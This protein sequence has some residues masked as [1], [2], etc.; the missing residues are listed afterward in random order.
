MTEFDPTNSGLFTPGPTFDSA[1]AGDAQRQAVD[2]LRGYAY[3][4]TASALAWLDLDA[5]AKLYLEVAEDY[6]TVAESALNAVQVKDT[7]HSGKISLKSPAVRNAVNAYVDLVARNPQRRVELHFLT[8]AA[9][10]QEQ[11][12]GDRPGGEAGLLYWRKAALAADLK[13][14]RVAFES[15][16]FSDSVRAFVRARDDDG[17]RRELLRNI[18]WECEQQNLGELLNELEDRLIILCTDRYR[19]RAVDSKRLI[20]VLLYHVLQKSILKDA[21]A[22]VLARADL[23][24]LINSA[25][26]VTLQQSTVDA[27]LARAVS[28][29][30]GAVSSQTTL[31]ISPAESNWFI[32]SDDIPTPRGIIP[33][34][35][36]RDAITKV[37]TTQKTAFLVGS[38]GMGKSLVGREAAREIAGDF[39]IFDLRDAELSEMRLRLKSVLGRI[40]EVVPRTMILEDAN[41]LDDPNVMMSLAMVINALNR[42]DRFA[43][44]TCYRTPSPRTLSALNLDVNAVIEIPYF[45]EDEVKVVVETN[46]GARD[47]WGKIAYVAGGVGHPQLV[48]AFVI[49][50][51]ARGWPRDALNDVV[52]SG[53]QSQD[54]EAAKDAARRQLVAALPE[55]PRTLLYRLSLLVGP[56]DR[57][58][59]LELGSIPP[60]LK[61]PGDQLD[62]LVGSWIEIIGRHRYRISPLIGNAGREA[63]SPTDQ[64]AIHIAIAVRMVSGKALNVSD[65]NI[66]FAHALLGKADRILFAL[67]GSILQ[68]DQATRD[69]L[70]EHFFML[71]SA[72][73]DIPIYADNRTVSSM[74]RSAQ[75]KLVAKGAE[76]QIIDCKIAMLREFLA[77]PVGELRDAQE[78]LG[79]G[80]VL[81]TAGIAKYLPDWFQLIL[82]FIDVSE[83]DRIPA[84]LNTIHKRRTSSGEPNWYSMLFVIGMAQLQS[85]SRLGEIFG[86]LDGVSQERRAILLEAYERGPGS[87]HI[88]VSGPWLEETKSEAFNWADAADRYSRM[89]EHAHRWGIKRLAAEC[90]VARAVMLDEYGHRPEDALHALDEAAVVL[91]DD[92]IIARA[93]A[94]ILWRHDEHMG[95][96]VIMRGIADRISHDEPI[97][98]CFALREAAISAAKI[99]DWT[100]AERWFDEAKVSAD[101]AIADDMLPMGVG[102]GID[103]AVAAFE[104]GRPSEAIARFAKSLTDL[105]KI[106]P[107]LSLRAAYC[108]RVAR[109]AVLWLQSKVEKLDVLIEHQPIQVPPGT[110]SNPQPLEAI[111]E[112]P[113]GSIDVA[114]YLLAQVEV[115]SGA[116][117]G[118]ASTL[119]KRLE[120]GMIPA[121]EV[122]LRGKWLERAI[123][124]SDANIFAKHFREWLEGVAYLEAQKS[125]NFN[126]LNP[127]RGEVP[128]LLDTEL[129]TEHV[130][131]NAEDAVLAFFITPILDGRNVEFTEL[132][133]R[134]AAQMGNSFPGAGL[135]AQSREETS[136]DDLNQVVARMSSSLLKE[137]HLEPK[138][139]WLIGLRLFEKGRK[140][141]FKFLLLPRVAEWMRMQWTR[142]IANERFRLRRPIVN[143]PA[144]EGALANEYD[145]QQFVAALLLACEDTV[146]V[147]LNSNYRDELRR[148]AAGQ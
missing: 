18:H 39:A 83:S 63:L 16:D 137:Q 141:N 145:D 25:T 30:S 140:S 107:A 135:F 75:F 45:T 55:A 44:I 99:E 121:C 112:L 12:I 69:S 54:V 34:P 131:L 73:T 65:A 11:R 67:A 61:A 84:D 51:S 128:P 20:N 132:E 113:L 56:F 106:D 19:T 31:A 72:R 92:V 38:T 119:S 1:P 6:A 42:R 116:D 98:R 89:F 17:V 95:A 76:W 64:Q 122:M 96:V 133:S 105:E 115:I 91:G 78:L 147:S 124:N 125:T 109:H 15:T 136:A 36:V 81:N 53:L 86:E 10:T 57:P 3:Q 68:A 14:L 143:V 4:V 110:C 59:A 97:A 2:A 114:W 49:G 144:I 40:G 93:R 8:T 46:G 27:L 22:R 111:K 142:I 102:L 117:V 26:S 87:Y 24:R 23:D 130:R 127:L 5:N 146:A 52:L 43:V 60:R 104:S 48:H 88:L 28:P 126:A 9:I 108:H 123:L 118:V 85:V 74:L 139:I 29:L 58:L 66:V 77:E 7:A 32:S 100:L 101:R 82:R 33:R 41:Y 50:M 129:S 120:Q 35:S 79:L 148:L 13:P 134:L 70:S 71:R 47:V 94:R 37:L 62:Y 138:Q 80:V 90:Y 21:T 103:A